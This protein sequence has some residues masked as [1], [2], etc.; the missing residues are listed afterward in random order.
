MTVQISSLKRRSEL[1]V[2]FVAFSRQAFLRRLFQSI[3]VLQVFSSDDDEGVPTSEIQIFR[4]V[5][6]H[7]RRSERPSF[8]EW[9]PL[10]Q[11]QA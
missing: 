3:R 6:G 9:H 11:Q 5:Q 7:P 2:N 4:P 8:T 1:R 10:V